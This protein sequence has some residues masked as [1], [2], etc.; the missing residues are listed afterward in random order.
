MSSRDRAEL[1]R[2]D[3]AFERALL[4]S[5]RADGPAAEA[6]R[7]VTKQAWARFAA[8]IVAVSC[9][10]RNAD[11]ADN[12]RRPRAGTARL[13]QPWGPAR[14]LVLGAIGGGVMV[15]AFA[16]WRGEKTA[17]SLPAAA[18]TPDV[19]RRGLETR[20]APR[21]MVS[22]TVSQAPPAPQ[23][24]QSTVGQSTVGRTGLAPLKPAE[25][26]KMARSWSRLAGTAPSDRAPSSN[27]AAEVAALDAARSAASRGAFD[28]TLRLVSQY[29][30]DF[31][32]GELAADADVVAIEALA[33]KSD[34]P[35][36]GRD[37]ARFLAQ[38]PNDPHAMR[39][40]Q[41]LAS[42]QHP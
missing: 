38:Y 19:S 7:E 14:W 35:E 41:L 3:R 36:A 15:G 23:D 24:G 4:E 31:P 6:S 32:N 1:D 2:S 20:D 29:R 42:H 21:K 28:E 13:P 5:A 40:R 22:S 25:R 18:F 34:W 26:K 10:P 17:M 16:K 12:Q 11:L 39:V 37:A 27:L 30:Y 8:T 33:A 9:A